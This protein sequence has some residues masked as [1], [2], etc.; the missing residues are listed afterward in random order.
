MLK[1]IMS[2]GSGGLC[3]FRPKRCCAEKYFHFP[4]SIHSEDDNFHGE[5]KPEKPEH[6]VRPETG[7]TGAGRLDTADGAAEIVDAYCCSASSARW[8]EKS[9]FN[10]QKIIPNAT[11]LIGS[12]VIHSD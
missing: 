3:K 8:D 4:Y 9:C 5:R 11:V 10:T 2:I 1:C 12:K 6:N 7:N